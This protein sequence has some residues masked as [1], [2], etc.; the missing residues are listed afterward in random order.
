MV[1]EVWL[2]RPIKVLVRPSL[3]KCLQ[4]LRVAAL[5]IT[6]SL[7]IRQVQVKITRDTTW[8]PPSAN[9][10]LQLPWQAAYP[11]LLPLW[12][13][14]LANEKKLAQVVVSKLLSSQIFAA[15]DARCYAWQ[16]PRHCGMQSPH[17]TTSIRQC[18]V[19]IDGPRIFDAGK[20]QEKNE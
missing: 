20:K 5:E 1:F 16:G 18:H 14:L 19:T 6:N 7:L 17:P 15:E 9:M 3:L 10:T 12:L 13:Q 11:S 8:R 4:I 2:T